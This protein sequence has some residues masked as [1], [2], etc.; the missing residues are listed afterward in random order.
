MYPLST[1]APKRSG[2]Y[3]VK[4]SNNML[5]IILKDNMYKRKGL[6]KPVEHKAA[7]SDSYWQHLS[8]YFS[9]ISETNDSVKLS[10]YIW[11]HITSKFCLHGGEI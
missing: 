11:F 7:I 3:R 5:D 8:S 1:G 2:L 10:N 4:R 9:D 6:D